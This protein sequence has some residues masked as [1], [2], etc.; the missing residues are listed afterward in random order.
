M[1][2]LAITFTGAV[3]AAIA[4][5][6]VAAG[7]ATRVGSNGDDAGT[8]RASRC[9]RVALFTAAVGATTAAG[10]SA[11]CGSPGT[12]VVNGGLLEPGE[13][14]SAATVRD[15]FVAVSVAATEAAEGA[16][17][18]RPR[19]DGCRLGSVPAAEGVGE[20]PPLLTE[21]SCVT[22]VLLRFGRT[23]VVGRPDVELAVLSG[24]GAD[25]TSAYA[26][27]GAAIEMAAPIPAAIA[28]AWSQP[29]TGSWR[30]RPEVLAWPAVTDPASRATI[31]TIQM[32]LSD[33]N[34]LLR[35]VCCVT[36]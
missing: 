30:R 3:A 25:E 31:S 26:K 29:T 34:C 22:P 23:L 9:M 13:G 24:A 10:V 14:V 36:F 21:S 28:P 2:G 35:N 7:S 19:P 20:D 16:A 15:W 27:P 18:E 1:N 6:A 4:D 32:M 12:F 17:M 11:G 33:A 8:L 5:I